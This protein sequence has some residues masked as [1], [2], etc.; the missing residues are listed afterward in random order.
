MQMRYANFY[1]R[2]PRGGRLDFWLYGWRKDKFLST[3]SA[4]RATDMLALFIPHGE[5]FLSTPSA[6]RATLDPWKGE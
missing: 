2:P 3:P 4:R 6:R 1:P 5:L